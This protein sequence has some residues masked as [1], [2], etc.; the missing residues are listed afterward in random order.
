MIIPFNCAVSRSV[1]ETTPAH[2]NPIQWHQSLGLARQICARVFRDG[3][4]AGEA[5]E[6]F[7]LTA[8]PGVTWDKAVE[9]IAEEISGAPGRRRAA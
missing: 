5:L 1:S 4:T 3:G 7:G 2:L 8:R 9:A 6:A